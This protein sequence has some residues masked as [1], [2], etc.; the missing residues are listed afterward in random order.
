MERDKERHLHGTPGAISC[1]SSENMR[2][3]VIEGEA[4]CADWVQV[5]DS[6]EGPEFILGQSNLNA[7][8][9]HN[10]K[11]CFTFNIWL[12]GSICI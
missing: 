1:Y 4:Q 7:F 12:Q 3:E 10:V 6:K 5:L 8:M 9:L 11:L 2:C